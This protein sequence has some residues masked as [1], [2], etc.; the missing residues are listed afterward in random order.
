MKNWKRYVKLTLKYSLY[1]L[2]AWSALM[3]FAYRGTTP[4]VGYRSTRQ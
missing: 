4:N 1:A 2:L 3:N